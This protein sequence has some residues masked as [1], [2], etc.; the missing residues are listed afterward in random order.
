M[1]GGRATLGLLA[2]GLLRVWALGMR[3]MRRL[4]C[5]SNARHGQGHDN[6]AC[7]GN[8]VHGGV[9]MC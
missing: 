9:V 2:T 4:E 7:H 6:M 3:A 5:G 1:G 8:G